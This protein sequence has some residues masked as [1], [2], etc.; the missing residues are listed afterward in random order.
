MLDMFSMNSW[1]S[2]LELLANSQC[3]KYANVFIV[4]NKPLQVNQ[5]NTLFMFKVDVA[6]HHLNIFT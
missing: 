6:S 3:Q 5:V 2:K 1:D 4:S